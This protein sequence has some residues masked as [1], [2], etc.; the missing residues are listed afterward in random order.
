[1]ETTVEKQRYEKKSFQLAKILVRRKFLRF[2]LFS[3]L[4][5]LFQVD[6]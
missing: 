4:K 1:M 2:F 3:S 5:S 6:E